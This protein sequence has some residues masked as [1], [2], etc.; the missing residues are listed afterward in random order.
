MELRSYTATLK[1]IPIAATTV[2]DIAEVNPAAEQPTELIGVIITQAGDSG[3]SGDANEDQVDIIISRITGSPTSGS[4]GT[5][6]V[7]TKG[8]SGSPAYG[9]VVE[10]GNTTNLSGG[11]EEEW[12]VEGVNNRVGIFYWPP[13]EA[14]LVIRGD[15]VLIIKTSALHTNAHELNA[16][17]VLGEIG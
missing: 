9:G 8:N 16:V 11:T 4:G 10:M 1:S 7:P 14:R 15:E 5:T 2:E 3:D 17:V 13:P 12:H 6:V